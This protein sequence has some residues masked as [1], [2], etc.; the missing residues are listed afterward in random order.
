MVFQYHKCIKLILVIL[1]S[2]PI[3]G[4]GQKV[5]VLTNQVKTV[6]AQINLAKGQLASVSSSEN[7]KL[8]LQNEQLIIE[9]Y[10]PELSEEG[11]FYEIIP[12]VQ[13]NGEGLTLVP[14]KAFRGDW[15]QDITPG[16]KKI[17]WVNLLQEY[18]QLEGT[19]ELKLIVNQWGER[20]LPY[21]CSLGMPTFTSK[22]RMPYFLAAGI[23]ALSIGAG[24][25]FKNKSQ[26]VYTNDYLPSSTFN[27][28]SPFYDDANKKHQTYLLLTYVGVGILAADITLFTI[29][30]RKFKQNKK[31]Y[32]EYCKTP[33]IGTL[34]N[35]NISTGLVSGAPGMKLT[36][37]F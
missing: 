9:Y 19:L 8:N 26:D 2:I 32:D 25:L 27:Q 1:M 3:F 16:N 36:L 23:G 14:F 18:T 12:S 13:L 5:E 24:Q 31:L 35:L 21:D 20:K 11:R 37:N 4:F 22:Q 6:S 33:D 10:L 7:I 29:K 30:Y 28:A 15:N 34:S 17:V